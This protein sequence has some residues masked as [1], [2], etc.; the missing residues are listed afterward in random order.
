MVCA[1]MMPVMQYPMAGMAM[2]PGM[3]GMQGMPL[4]PG[5]PQM[6][7]QPGSAA[8]TA[9]MLMPMGAPTQPQQ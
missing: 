2:Q 5:M 7:L 3:Q 6:Q 1:Q 8:Q 9:P 4:Q